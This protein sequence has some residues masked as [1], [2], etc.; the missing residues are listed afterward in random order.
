MVSVSDIVSLIWNSS[1][2]FVQFSDFLF[3]F[4]VI[5]SAG[6][7][8]SCILHQ[9]IEGKCKFLRVLM[10][11][12]MKGFSR[13]TIL[14]SKHDID[15][16]YHFSIRLIFIFP[17]LLCVLKYKWYILHIINELSWHPYHWCAVLLTY[18]ITVS[19]AFSETFFFSS[20]INFHLSFSVKQ[21]SS[22]TIGV[23]FGSKVVNVGGKSVKL[24]I[25]D[26][27]GQ[28]RFR[29]MKMAIC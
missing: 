20:C 18:S 7:G 11:K 13:S 17:L 4:L 5:G 6:T 8:K 19:L 15:S 28:E 3:K 23:E 2:S 14:Y 25:W 9:F 26:T 27:A 1:V 29:F 10:D 22:H 16:F 24:Q 12:M 21:D